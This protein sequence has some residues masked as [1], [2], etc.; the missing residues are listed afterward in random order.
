M[1]EP[2]FGTKA[3]VAWRP[4]GLI[5]WYGP[6]GSPLVLVTSWIALVGGS[7]PRLRTAWC[8]RSDSDSRYWPG[9]DF[10]LNV[11]HESDLEPIRRIMDKGKFCLHAEVD[12]TYSCLSGIT[13]IAPRLLECAVQIECVGGRL[14]ETAFDAELCGDVARVHR[15]GVNL[16]PLEIPDLCAIY[17]LSP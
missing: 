12:L 5:S 16:D 2:F 10:V 14:I 13:A 15:D 17:P 4:A 9:G 1:N 8:G 7:L 3:P 6:D 11:P